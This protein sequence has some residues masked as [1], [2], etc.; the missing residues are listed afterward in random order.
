MLRDN[1]FR[2]HSPADIIEQVGKTTLAVISQW[3]DGELD[4]VGWNDNRIVNRLYDLGDTGV[5]AARQTGLTPIDAA[6]VAVMDN[7][8]L[9]VGAVEAVGIDNRAELV[10]LTNCIDVN[11]LKTVE[12]A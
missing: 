10:K 6:V 3:T 2:E 12:T 1:W 7:V 8:L 5:W 4:R 11:R 9:A